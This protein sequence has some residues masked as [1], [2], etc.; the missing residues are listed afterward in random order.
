LFLLFWLGFPLVSFLSFCGFIN[1]FT[2]FCS[3]FLFH[4]LSLFCK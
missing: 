4:V 2:I 1:T 3:S